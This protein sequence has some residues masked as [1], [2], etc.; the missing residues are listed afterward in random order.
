MKNASPQI[1]VMHQLQEELTAIFENS[2]NLG[3][4]IIKLG[5]DITNFMKSEV[6]SVK[7][8]VKMSVGDCDPPLNF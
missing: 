8:E 5:K 4:G 3:E 6:R 7:S 1:E 2:K